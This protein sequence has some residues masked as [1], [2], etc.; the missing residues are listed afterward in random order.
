MQDGEIRSLYYGNNYANTGGE[1][2]LGYEGEIAP[3]QITSYRPSDVPEWYTG[4]IVYQIFPDRFA[5][6]EGWRERVERANAHINA[7]RSDIKRTVME[8]SG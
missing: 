7:R 6:D 5:R 1:G 8:G 4:G 2:R 3:Y